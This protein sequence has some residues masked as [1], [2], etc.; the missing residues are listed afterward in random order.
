MSVSSLV[1][2]YKLSAVWQLPLKGFSCNSMS[3]NYRQ[4]TWTV[5]VWL[6]SVSYCSVAVWWPA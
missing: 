6:M 1:S 4:S 3:R 2:S 5:I